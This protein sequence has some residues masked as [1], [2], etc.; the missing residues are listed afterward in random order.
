MSSKRWRHQHQQ[1]HL[2]SHDKGKLCR[3]R[4]NI[5]RNATKSPNVRPET[6]QKTYKL[7]FWPGFCYKIIIMTELHVKA[8]PAVKCDPHALHARTSNHALYWVPRLKAQLTAWR[9]RAISH[10]VSR[11][12]PTAAAR[13]PARVQSCGICSGQSGYGAGF[14]RVLRFPLPNLIPPIAPQSP[15]YIIRGWYKWPNSGR[16]TEWTQSHPTLKK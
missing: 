5:T 15:S 4:A 12:L 6:Y 16:S 7:Y 10:A 8:L 14:L 1:G 11:R 2:P 13:V 3:I 9:G